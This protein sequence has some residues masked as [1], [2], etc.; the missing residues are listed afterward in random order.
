MPEPVGRANTP[1][2]NVLLAGVAAAHPHTFHI[3]RQ[4]FLRRDIVARPDH[5]GLP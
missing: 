5:I 4:H 2:S 3:R 1:A